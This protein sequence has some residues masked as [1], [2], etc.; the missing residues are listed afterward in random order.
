M[1]FLY[2]DV[3]SFLLLSFPFCWKHLPAIL[4]RQFFWQQIILVYLR[5]S[6]FHLHS[7]SLF[8]LDIEFGVDSS[9]LSVLGKSYAIFLWSS[10]FLM[11]NLLSFKWIFALNVKCFCFWFFF[12]ATFKIF[13]SLL[14][15]FGCLIMRCQSMVIVKFILFGVHWFS[16]ICNFSWILNFLADLGKFQSLLKKKFLSVSLRNSNGMHIKSFYIYPH[17]SKSL[18]SF[19]NIF[20]LSL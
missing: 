7:W 2:F 3:P 18:F 13:F 12:L 4:L 20:S 1:F 10:W 11:R 15:A 17:I 5:I 16:W 6:L 8:S 14:V 19:K 9:F